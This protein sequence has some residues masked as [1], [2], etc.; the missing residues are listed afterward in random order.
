M[1]NV[2]YH[3]RDTKASSFFFYN[4]FQAVSDMI[5]QHTSLEGQQNNLN[6]FQTAIRIVREK[7]GYE[8]KALDM[9]HQPWLETSDDRDTVKYIEMQGFENATTHVSCV[10]NGHIYDG[11]LGT[12]LKLSRN[13]MKW[14][15]GDD[16]F[17]LKCYAI[18]KITVCDITNEK[19]SPPKKK[20]KM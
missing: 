7:F 9:Y 19:V 13:S 16:N 6:G 17:A 12:S 5:Q 4:R 20:R 18:Q 11:S 2:M 1:A 15:I 3:L 10:L 14:I 8:T